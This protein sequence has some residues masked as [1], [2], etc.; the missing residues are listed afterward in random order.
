[1]AKKKVVGAS[2]RQQISLPI[3]FYRIVNIKDCI[4]G[5]VPFFS[6]WE[7]NK[8]LLWIYSACKI[9]VLEI[10]YFHTRLKFLS[11]VENSSKERKTVYD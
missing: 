3:C 2:H 10:K 8:F 4:F 5:N 6:C 9:K 1:M 11:R 7:E